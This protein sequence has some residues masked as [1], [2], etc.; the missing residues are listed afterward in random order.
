MGRRTLHPMSY[1]FEFVPVAGTYHDVG[2]GIAR[3]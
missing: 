1:D 2:T 3:H